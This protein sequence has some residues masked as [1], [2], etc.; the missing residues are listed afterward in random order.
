[1]KGAVSQA[2]LIP[3]PPPPSLPAGYYTTFAQMATM[4]HEKRWRCGRYFVGG[5]REV[6]VAGSGFGVRPLRVLA[7]NG[8]FG[9]APVPM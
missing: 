3:P 2:E 9:F 6:A 5:E 7:I 4:G 8:C 1:M